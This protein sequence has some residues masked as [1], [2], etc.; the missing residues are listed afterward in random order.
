MVRAEYD[1]LSETTIGFAYGRNYSTQDNV[2]VLLSN[3]R[4]NGDITV[5]PN[6][7]PYHVRGEAADVTLRSR[8][9]TGPVTHQ[10]ALIGN[11]V[12]RD[13]IF[14]TTPGIAPSRVENIY[15]DF[16]VPRP[17]IAGLD[18]FPRVSNSTVFR[19]VAL[20]DTLSILD[21]RVQLILGGRFQ[22]ILADAFNRAGART[23]RY[24]EDALTPAIA[25][26][27]RPW[28][29]L[30]LYANYIEQLNQ[31]PVA[32]ANARNAGEV[33]QPALSRQYEVGAKLDYRS[34]G[35]QLA[36]YQIS[37]QSGALG[38]DNVFGPIG[39][40][41]NRGAELLVF[42]EPLP[43]VRILGGGSL[44]EGR[45]TRTAGGI[46]N[47]KT[48]PA[49]PAVQLNTSA[50]WDPPMVPGGTV[51]TRVTYTDGS[52][53]DP[54]NTVRVPSWTRLDL[55]GRYTFELNGKAVTARFD[56]LNVNGIDYYVARAGSVSLGNPRT[57]LFSL[58][59]DF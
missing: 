35:A 22:N 19:S 9:V 14:F 37:Q 1:I 54:A 29:P 45:L 26:S 4:P 36:F 5:T 12:R 28:R 25:L 58:S 20:A 46:N 49:V 23:S 11:S 56:I 44:I 51:F 30:S 8:F 55:G 53:I 32:P 21:E 6:F 41:R 15:R 33:F 27:L 10:V 42:G 34:V 47:G 50:E 31:G 3:L 48:A 17:S 52:Y 40:Q 59:S 57:F 43:G 38:A 18:K 24:D 39:Q 7:G 13:D 2:G 16:L